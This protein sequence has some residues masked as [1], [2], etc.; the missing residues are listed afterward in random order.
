MKARNI[1]LI[2]IMAV[3]LFLFFFCI[4]R[5][6]NHTKVGFLCAILS[7]VMVIVVGYLLL[8]PKMKPVEVSGPYDVKT[9]LDYFVD[10]TRI[11]PYDK[12][13]G[14]RELPVQ[15]WYPA[16]QEKTDCPLIIF[17]HGSFGVKESNETL[18]R[19]L[20]KNGYVVCSIDH[21]Y[22]AFSTRLS[23]GKKV[24]IHMDYV[25][26]IGTDQPKKNPEKSVEHFKKWM[27]IRMKDIDCVLDSILEQIGTN[28]E[29]TVYQKID[30]TKIGLIGHSL[31][32]SAVL[33]EG[34]VREEIDAVIAL[35]S[36]FLADIKGV[37]EAG[38]FIFEDAEYPIPVMNVYSD[39]S[40]DHLKEWKQYAENEK[41]LNSTR[42]DVKNVHLTGLGH[43]ALTD[44]SLTSPFLTTVLDGMESKQT[45][46]ENLTKINEVCLEFLNEYLK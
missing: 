28:T 40:W 4:I 34:R 22:H 3:E 9:Q 1:I 11:D 41:L 44:F 24:R 43:L 7:L 17:S 46:Q 21:T 18:Y 10:E 12:N 32:G 15:F 29:S 36:P 2:I 19:C 14:Y 30:A 42:D 37:D 33:G 23:N 26:E 38:N 39:A 16:N 8:F 45:P 6:S 31:G 27:D 5:K 13:G 35:E 20:A 25:K